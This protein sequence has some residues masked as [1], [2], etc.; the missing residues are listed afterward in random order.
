MLSCDVNTRGHTQW[1]LFRVRNMR[2]GVPYRFNII[3]MMKPDSLFSSG[4]RPLVY[5][6]AEALQKAVGW[7]RAGS[8]ICY[9]QNQYSYMGSAK[10]KKKDNTPARDTSLPFYTLSMTITF[11]HADDTA[12]IAQCYPYTYSRLQHYLGGITNARS[13]VIRRET[14]WYALVVQCWFLPNALHISHYHTVMSCESITEAK[15][16]TR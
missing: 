14:L 5:S 1:F 4:M 13:D 12:F 9:Y 11:P 8:D 16:L 7:V 3:N 2:P 6:E 10:K 15:Q